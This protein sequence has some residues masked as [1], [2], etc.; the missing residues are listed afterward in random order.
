MVPFGG[1]VEEVRRS[2]HRLPQT[3]HGE[4]SAADRIWDVGD[5]WGRISARSVRNAVGNE[6]YMDTAGNCGTVGGVMT[7]I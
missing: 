3:D 1:N 6:L 7:N 2:T 4:A 5:V